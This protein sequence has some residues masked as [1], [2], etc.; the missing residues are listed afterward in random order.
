MESDTSLKSD[1]DILVEKYTVNIVDYENYEKLLEIKEID[2][3]NFRT[4]KYNETS[5]DSKY[6][7]EGVHEFHK[8]EKRKVRY[9][10]DNKFIDEKDYEDIL[11]DF[12]WNL[13]NKGEKFLL[14]SM[15]YKR[16]RPDVFDRIAFVEDKVKKY[17]NSLIRY[18]IIGIGLLIGGIISIEDGE[19]S[20]YFYIGY[21]IFG[22]ALSLYVRWYDF[23]YI[24]AYLKNKKIIDRYK[25]K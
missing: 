13:V 7:V 9:C 11:Q 6:C 16:K 12:G 15:E 14:W 2:G 20:L 4:V 22:L 18:Y 5:I 1:K 25:L 21:I 8:G 19:Y 10:V 3:W 24:R 17:T 23:K